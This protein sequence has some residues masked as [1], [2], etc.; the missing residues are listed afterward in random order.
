[1]TFPFRLLGFLPL[2]FFLVNWSH[3]A[4]N[5][6]PGNILWLCNLNNLLLAFGL[7]FDLPVLARIAILWLIPGLPLWLIESWEFQGFPMTSVLS[8]IGALVFGLMI[9]RTIRMKSNTWV[10]ATLYALGVQ[11][12]CRLVTRKELN[13]N[14]AFAP[15]SGWDQ[16]FPR[17]FYF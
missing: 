9:L 4:A 2:I 6:D 13:V 3:H 15:Y 16:V 7:L 17:Y 5:G 11:R 1:M 8:H 10:Y 12:L 14:V